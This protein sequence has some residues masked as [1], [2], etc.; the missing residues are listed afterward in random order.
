MDA[1]ATAVAAAHDGADEAL[2]NV[3]EIIDIDK[4]ASTDKT[5]N[6]SEK[7]QGDPG[8]RNNGGETLKTLDT[9]G[10]EEAVEA[11]IVNNG[12]PIISRRRDSNAAQ[13]RSLE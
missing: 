12:V 6:A 8:Q 5:S 1:E 13:C 4:T 10:I 2:I 3:D 9:M 7:M 11:G